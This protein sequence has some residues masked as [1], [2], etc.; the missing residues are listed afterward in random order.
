MLLCQTH[1]TLIWNNKEWFLN[2]SFDLIITMLNNMI[3][4]RFW[5][6]IKSVPWLGTWSD[7]CPS[8]FP[9]N[10]SYVSNYVCI[11]T[12]TLTVSNKSDLFL[13]RCTSVTIFTPREMKIC[14][15][16]RSSS[17]WCSEKQAKSLLSVCTTP[18]LWQI[19][20]VSNGV[21]RMAKILHSWDSFTLIWGLSK[22][23]L[24]ANQ[25][26]HQHLHWPSSPSG[27]WPKSNRTSQTRTKQVVYSTVTQNRSLVVL[28]VQSF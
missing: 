16:T 14:E 7:L 24:L 15:N 19:A 27:M 4:Y 1:F 12:I 13:A 17:I 18:G 5:L 21:V 20:E 6:F 26:I 8:F 10:S 11:Y 25:L 3:L 28:K 22:P 2:K 23:L 9:V